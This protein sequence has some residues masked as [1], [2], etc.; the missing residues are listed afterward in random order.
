MPKLKQNDGGQVLGCMLYLAGGLDQVTAMQ[1]QLLAQLAL[2]DILLT[3]WHCSSL[4]SGIFCNSCCCYFPG[5][6]P[7][8][9][10]TGRSWDRLCPSVLPGLSWQSEPD[11]S[12]K[13][14]LHGSEALTSYTRATLWYSDLGH[15]TSKLRNNTSCLSASWLIFYFLEFWDRVSL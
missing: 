6:K 7:W 10:C 2:S 15:L 8:V 1:P 4:I 14:S 3:R 5:Q 11:G 13:K 9:V 12:L